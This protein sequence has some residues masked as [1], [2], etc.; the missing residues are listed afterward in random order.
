MA[1]QYRKLLAAASLGLLTLFQGQAHAQDYPNKPVTIVV[2]YSAGGS[3]DVIAR[4][5][6]Q[7]L[8]NA[9]GQR[10][11]VQ[12]RPG[13]S[14]MIASEFVARSAPDGYTLL[15]A[16]STELA[17]N[18]GVFSKM[19]Y[20]P[21]KD[22]T[23]VIQYSV[24]PN[25]LLVRPN[26]PSLTAKNINELVEF[27]KTHPGKLTFGS[28]G[29]GSSQDMAAELFMTLTGTKAMQVP[30]KGGADSITALMGGQIDMNFSPLPEALPHIRSGKLLPLALTSAQRS[31]VVPEVP[32]MAEAGVA[33]YEFS[34]WHALVA[35]AGT[36][37]PVID[38]INGVL[39]KALQG[40]LGDKLRNIGVT[41]MGGT[42]QQAA[43]RQQATIKKFQE[44]IKAANRPKL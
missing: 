21:V 39:Q 23:P 38:K 20:D 24:Q 12:N 29:N 19:A 1:I 33:G 14:A 6:A 18:L 26:S 22:F 3:G 13:A 35:P 17:A 30:Y 5:V 41:V 28:A 37:Q 11:I 7:E 43:E 15:S 36:P 32:T 44:L 2:G 10:F 16:S 4:L 9:L 31:S 8:S 40:E 25:V 34:G 27:A 42:P